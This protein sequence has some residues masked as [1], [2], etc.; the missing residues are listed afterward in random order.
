MKKQGFQDKHLNKVAPN[1]KIFHD[2]DVNEE[3]LLMEFLLKTLSN[4]S[5]N[6]IKTL[7]SNRQILVN[8]VTQ[9]KFNYELKKGDKVTV[10]LNPDGHKTKTSC[11]FQILYEDKN[12]IAINKPSGVL[13]VNLDDKS[14][15]KNAF[16]MMQQYVKEI[17]P[18][19]NL[20]IVHRIDK[21]TSGVLLFTKNIDAVEVLQNDWN[22]LVIDREY[23]AICEGIFNK[24]E[25]TK[26]SYL[27]E[28]NTKLVYSIKDETKGKKAITN[29]KVI[30][31]KNNL[32][33]V[34]VNIETGRKNQIRVHMKEL[35][36][37]V[38]G[39]K[40][41]HSNLDPLKRLGLHAHTLSFNDPFSSKEI[42][43]VAPTPMEFK[44]LFK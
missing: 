6:N 8:K 23:D 30:S 32:S 34:K 10:S 9:T 21:D 28:G 4:Q 11:P 31:E 18:K 14:N 37:P 16:Y 43:I 38:V 39:D 19:N 24:K 20:F 13:S 40:K 25:G 36:H 7:L 27:V 5:R 42:K 2:Y 41:Y 29:Y 12:Y 35:S 22:D 1:K 44:K 3:S 26:I 33:L 15:N 17:N